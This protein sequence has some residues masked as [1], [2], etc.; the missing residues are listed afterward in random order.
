MGILNKMRTA[1]KSKTTVEKINLI[2]DVISGLGCGMG[3]AIIGDKLCE[4]RTVVE[5]VCVKTAVTG[6]GLVAYDVSSRALKENYGEPVGNII[7]RARARA[8]EEKMKE[9]VTNE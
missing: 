3:A 7:D 5:K 2:L 4:G 1:W 8:A 6:L 9:A